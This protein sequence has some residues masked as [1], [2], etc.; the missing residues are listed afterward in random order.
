MYINLVNYWGYLV[1][2]LS[3][4]DSGS[5]EDHRFCGLELVWA[6]LHSFHL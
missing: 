3:L 4:F 6:C 2:F 1:H 5:A